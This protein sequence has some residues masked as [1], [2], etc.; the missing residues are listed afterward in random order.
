VKVEKTPPTEYEIGKI[1]ECVKSNSP[2]D[3][4]LL[5]TMK[6]TIQREHAFRDV[7]LDDIDFNDKTIRFKCTKG[8]QPYRT[9][10]STRTINALRD[11]IVTHRLKPKEGHKDCLF[12][13]DSKER[14]YEKKLDSVL[15]YCAVHCD[16]KEKVHP[17]V[18]RHSRVKD[19]REQG[20]NWEE[21]MTITGHKNIMSLSSYIHKEGFDKVQEKLNGNHEEIEPEK[22]MSDNTDIQKE[23]DML[24]LKLQL[25][26][27]EKEI[28]EKE[29]QNLEMQLQ[30]NTHEILPLKTNV[31]QQKGYV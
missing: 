1:L 7:T 29:K 31:D 8:G 3:Y 12:I 25:A 28:V 27:K 14:V 4:A 21:T 17:H 16:I 5:L 13:L 23:L 11:Y 22:Q 6:D 15:R 10:I 18:L 20:Y 26:E 30:L 2:L 9:N 19:L 24:K